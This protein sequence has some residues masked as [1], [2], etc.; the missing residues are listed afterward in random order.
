VWPVFV[1]AE[2]YQGGYV[3]PPEDK[4]AKNYR[5]PLILSTVMLFAFGADAD[6]KKKKK[7]KGPPPTG[8][9]EVNEGQPQCYYTPDWLSLNEI[10]RRMKRS[11]AMDEVLNQWRG[12]RDDGV[13]MKEQVIDD[14]ETVLLGRPEKIEA[15]VADNLVQC[16]AGNVGAWTTW[17]KGLKASL[18]VGECNHPLD[19]TMFDYLDIGT[20]WQRPLKICKGDRIK[21]SGTVNDQYRTSDSSPWITVVGDPAQPTSG[22]DEPCNIE[23]C[24]AGMLVMKFVGKATGF[25]TIVPVGVSAVF[26]APEDGE[27]SYRINDTSFYDNIW[28]TSGSVIDHTAIEVS[29][30]K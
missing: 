23:G 10:D 26:S 11:E 25:E 14:V 27:I 3:E 17:T 2:R 15:F 4:M 8:W 7:R 6:A 20:G 28:H 22:G 30:A 24:M 9:Q 1:C 5:L 21:I 13:A 19:Y 16:E 18:T 29:P 12:Q